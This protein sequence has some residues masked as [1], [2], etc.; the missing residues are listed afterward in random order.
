MIHMSWTSKV[1]GIEELIT[2]RYE[3]K[4]RGDTYEMRFYEGEGVK[5][6]PTMLIA[7]NR[8]LD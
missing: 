4:Y 3:L 1:A 8:K 2:N 7:M 6:L 5:E